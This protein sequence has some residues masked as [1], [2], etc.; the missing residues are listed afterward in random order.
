M[1]IVAGLRFPYSRVMLPRTRLAYIHLRNLLTDAKRDRAA[2]LSAYV[3]V[4]LP[5][6]FVVL[7]MQRGEVVNATMVDKNG[8]RSVAISSALERIPPEPEYGEICFHEADNEQLASMFLSQTKPADPWPSDLK[9]N[10]PAV[11]F[12]FLMS[13]MFDGV[14][15]IR[16]EDDG[17]GDAARRHESQALARAGT[18]LAVIRTD[19]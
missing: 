11:L 13:V 10:D 6:E 1:P 9:V 17:I 18:L 12:P 14:H 8:S 5:E 4:W 7:Y 16:V 19:T 2:R 15:D 3:A